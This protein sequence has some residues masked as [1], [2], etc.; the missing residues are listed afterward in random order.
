MILRHAQNLLQKVIK[1]RTARVILNYLSSIGVE[2]IFG[3]PAGSVNAIFDELYDMPH[4]QPIVSKHEGG[5]SYIAAAYAR[6]TGKLGV[7]IGSSG[8]GTTNFVTGAANA[9]RE[10]LPMLFLT[11]H[12]PVQTLGLNASQE[13]DAT[14]IFHPVTKYSVTVKNSEDVLSEISR[15]VE[16]ALTGVPGPVHVGLPINV[17]LSDTSIGELPPLPIT[18]RILPSAQAVK[19]AS[20]VI[21]KVKGGFIFIG[22]GARGAVSEVLEVASLLS[23]PIVTTPQAKGLIPDSHPM[24]KG[25]FGFAGHEE[26]TELV[27]DSNYEAALI[28]GSSLGETA[29][30]NYNRALGANRTLIHIDIDE[31]VFNR[32][33]DSDVTICGDAKATLSLMIKELR[34]LEIDARTKDIFAKKEIIERPISG[35]YNTENVLRTLQNLLPRDTRYTVDIGEFMAYVIHHMR[36]YESHTFDI[37]VHFGPMGIGIGSSIGLRLADSNHPVVCITGDGCFF[38]HGMEILTAKEYN[39]PVVFVVF[40]N[41]RLGMVCH[42]HNL[43]YGRSHPCFEQVPVNIAEMASSLGIF[44]ARVE[45]MEDL[46]SELVQMMLSKQGPSVLEVALVDKSIP[47]MGDRVKFLSSFSE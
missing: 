19:H 33:Y 27:T 9:M 4:I 17:Q 12:V 11:G 16:I 40:N 5:A 22:Q 10:H 13:L 14:M 30:N 39:L 25:V 1:L 45:K 26:S 35:G 36:V 18:E 24:L 46:N 6:E 2:Y 44:S 29:T 15:A 31:S 3:I 37:N 38:M 47:P 32:V 8:P 20:Q 34:E 7:C 42:G 23:W 28:I 21:G 41:A 43:Q